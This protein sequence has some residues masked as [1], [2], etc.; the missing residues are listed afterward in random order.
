[1]SLGELNVLHMKR[2]VI[3]VK[4]QITLLSVVPK[5]PSSKP[6]SQKQVRSF[7]DVDYA[8]E[9]QYY[10]EI[11]T[12]TTHS[13]TVFLIDESYKRKLFATM[14]INSRDIKF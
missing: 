1:M 5:A 12:L 6:S 11:S 10:E 7:H 9:S 14:S 2:F 8:N 4:D 13:D 3:V